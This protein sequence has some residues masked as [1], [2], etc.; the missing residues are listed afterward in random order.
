MT[1]R[2]LV[3]FHAATVFFL[4]CGPSREETLLK[5]APK[6]G[7]EMARALVA[8][9]TVWACHCRDA[10][11][12]PTLKAAEMLRDA[13]VSPTEAS[14]TLNSKHLRPYVDRI[15]RCARDEYKFDGEW[16]EYQAWLTRSFKQAK[17]LDSLRTAMVE[18]GTDT[19]TSYPDKLRIL[20]EMEAGFRACKSVPGVVMTL[21]GQARTYNALHDPVHGLVCYRKALSER[22]FGGRHTMTMS[23]TTTIGFVLRQEGKIDS[24]L[25]YYNRSLHM[26]EESRDPVGTSRAYKFLALYYQSIGQYGTAY[27]LLQRSV[28][29]CREFK[30]GNDEFR[31]LLNILQLQ[32]RFGIWESMGELFDR[33]DHLL[34]ETDDGTYTTLPRERME[35]EIGLIKGPYLMVTSQEKAG[36]NLFRSLRS[37]ARRCA[38]RE[39]Y[40][41]LL[42]AWSSALLNSGKPREAA[43]LAREGLAY[44]DS[45]TLE[46]EA[47]RLN[48]VIADAACQLGE[49]GEAKQALQEFRRLVGT[50]ETEFRTYWVNHDKIVICLALASGDTLLAERHA[51]AAMTR[52]ERFLI[53]LDQSVQACLFLDDCRPLRKSIHEMLRRSPEAGYGFEMA[54]RGLYRTMGTGASKSPSFFSRGGASLTQ[55][56]ASLGRNIQGRV[57]NAG[58]THVVYFVGSN[59]ILRWTASPTGVLRETV[60]VPSSKIKEEVE[61]VS[62]GLAAQNPSSEDP[63][64]LDALTNL[65]TLLPSSLGNSGAPQLFLVSPDLC[66]FNFP[67]EAINLGPKNT[68]RPLI[69]SHDV[70]YVRQVLPRRAL[71]SSPRNGLVLVSPTYPAAL[72]RR[73]PSLG[74]LPDAAQEATFVTATS[75][76]SVSLSG[77]AATKQALKA[78][79]EKPDFLYVA[80]H[81]IQD[82]G[83]PYVSFLPLAA[84][85]SAEPSEALLEYG[86]IRDADLSGCELVVLSGCATGAAYANAQTSAPSLGDAFL[87]AG[88]RA[89][90]HTRWRVQDDESYALARAFITGW[91]SGKTPVAALNQA[92]RDAWRLAKEPSTTWTSYSVTLSEIPSVTNGHASSI[93]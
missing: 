44:A 17:D 75:P 34:G 38:D 61:T 8:P 50:A 1:P 3:W 59:S 28:Q 85:D 91:A 12:L 52:L 53:P 11:L 40:A 4:G 25:V 5:L 22:E 42:Y 57:K 65:A 76:H 64:V 80:S 77:T 56:C 21:E 46:M 24:M 89:V 92:Q 55:R 58:S 45:A 68:Y 81:F 74:A 13:V 27:E 83:S 79:W 70:A 10:G 37:P 69:E 82:T 78:A 67:F 23:L 86:D 7:R 51:L 93:H 66:L 26:A 84:P 19:L 43:T 54:W 33:A 35:L 41:Q 6:L 14:Y 31:S 36:D 2:G 30:G 32:A 90:V 48:L 15:E 73:Y 29:R 87:D 47:I 72:T 49:P 9:D 62:R 60:P 16:T 18:L 88:A 63:S 39:K 20:R 71:K